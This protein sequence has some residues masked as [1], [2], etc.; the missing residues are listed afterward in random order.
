VRFTDP[1]TN[2]AYEILD[3]SAS[4]GRSDGERAIAV[5]LRERQ[6]DDLSAEELFLLGRALNWAGRH[7]EAV[8]ALE[9]ACKLAPHSLALRHALQ[10][11]M[12]NA[13]AGDSEQLLAAWDRFRRDI[14]PPGFWLLVEADLLVQVGTGEF[15]EPDSTWRTGDPFVDENCIRRAGDCLRKALRLDPTLASGTEWNERYAPVW[16]LHEYADLQV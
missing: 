1:R 12:N 15:T 9:R 7:A 16:T 10:D 3:A 11:H 5:L 8:T 13:H 2:A 6:H 4:H 14:G